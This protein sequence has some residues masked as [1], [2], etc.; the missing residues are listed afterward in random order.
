MRG[1]VGNAST[2]SAVAAGHRCGSR[3]RRSARGTTRGRRRADGPRASAPSC[4]VRTGTRRSWRTVATLAGPAQPVRATRISST[5]SNID[6]AWRA[7]TSARP[8]AS[9]QPIATVT[10]G[11]PRVRVERAELLERVVLVVARRDRHAGRDRGG[12]RPRG[13]RRPAARYA[14]DVDAGGIGSPGVKSTRLRVGAER[15]GDLGQLRRRRDRRAARR[16]K[17][18]VSTSWRAARVPTAP[19]PT[20]SAVV[21]GIRAPRARANRRSSA[22]R[23]PCRASARCSPIA[24]ATPSTSSTRLKTFTTRECIEQ[25]RTRRTGRARAHGL[26]RCVACPGL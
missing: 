19:T 15:V 11:A 23:R 26:L 21:T 25:A 5:F 3:G 8:G 22:A 1:D 9:P 16:S 12:R 14:T 17:P 6:A 18:G 2:S 10:P 13:R 20:T 7:S 4:H 24:P